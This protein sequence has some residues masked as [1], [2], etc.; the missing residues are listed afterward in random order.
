[1]LIIFSA[2]ISITSCGILTPNASYTI[3]NLGFS[4]PNFI[5]IYAHVDY[6][7][8]A[9][10][11][12]YLIDTYIIAFDIYDTQGNI[13]TST[14]MLLYIPLEDPD[15]PS[16]EPTFE[17]AVVGWHEQYTI[18]EV[19]PRHIEIWPAWNVSFNQYVIPFVLQDDGSWVADTRA[20]VT[21]G[22]GTEPQGEND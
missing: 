4:Y 16:I 6:E 22:D 2:I 12:E 17:Q 5:T 19:V 15:N 13:Y 11:E 10:N 14:D 8:I 3:T 18:R 9:N 20:P 1:M 21:V 7:I